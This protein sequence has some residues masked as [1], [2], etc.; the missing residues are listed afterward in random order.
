MEPWATNHCPK[1]SLT[2]ICAPKLQPPQPVK[3]LS[4]LSCSSPLPFLLHFQLWH[5]L[6]YSKIGSPLHGVGDRASSLHS[7]AGNFLNVNSLILKIRTF[8]V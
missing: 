1:P 3:L 7:A 5:A 2:K 8:E 4:S 6:L